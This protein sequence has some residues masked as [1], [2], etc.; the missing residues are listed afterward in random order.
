MVD[1]IKEDGIGSEFY[2][3][4]KDGKTTTAGEFFRWQFTEKC[5]ND[6]MDYLS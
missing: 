2:N 5:G 3:L 1:D 6:A 4:F